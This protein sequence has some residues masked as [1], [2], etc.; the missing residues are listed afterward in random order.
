MKRR[1]GTVSFCGLVDADGPSL[2]SFSVFV[3]LGD[4]LSS[5]LL[6]SVK[7]K[8]DILMIYRYSTS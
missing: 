1:G 8:N 2:T 5:S 3:G 6:L 4:F 7:E